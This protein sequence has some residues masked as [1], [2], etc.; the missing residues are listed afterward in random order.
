MS[1]DHARAAQLLAS[2]A[3]TQP[4][5]TDLARKAL[6]EAISAGDMQLALSLAPAVPAA[7]LPVD[8]RLLLVT[9]EIKRRH[10][11]RAVQWL[12]P[13]GGS[14]DLRELAPLITAW[15]A[16][17]RGDQQGALAAFDQLPARSLLAPIEAEQ[18][19]FVLLKFRRT[20]T[21]NRSPVRRS[22]A[23]A[24]VK[25]GCGSPSPTPSLP[26]A[27]APGR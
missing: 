26:P 1:G 7:K 22:A 4:Q 13:A 17:E 15:M 3:G 9:E 25:R 2:L 10:P 6:S 23:L 21:R 12:A 5:Q 11:E 24:R 16:A 18:R 14:G 27:T 20:G 8:A 19:A